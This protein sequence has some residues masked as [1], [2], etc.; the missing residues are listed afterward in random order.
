MD[1]LPCFLHSK[2]LS[3]FTRRERELSSPPLMLR[4]TRVYC[5]LFKKIF[6][7]DLDPSANTKLI[8]APQLKVSISSSVIFCLMSQVWTSPKKHTNM[9]VC[10]N[11]H[12]KFYYKKWASSSKHI[13]KK[14][15]NGSFISP[16][17]A[18]DY[19]PSQNPAWNEHI[20]E[21]LLSKEAK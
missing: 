20:F 13:R 8:W 21:L 7:D 6:E 12:S 17:G 1:P 10:P 2:L 18:L 3:F 16:R 11:A 4:Q 15:Q 14:S 9:L 5:G 19:G